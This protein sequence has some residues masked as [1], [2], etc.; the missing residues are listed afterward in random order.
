MFKASSSTCRNTLDFLDDSDTIGH[1]AKISGFLKRKP[2]KITPA[3]FVKAVILAGAKDSISFNAIAWHAGQIGGATSSRQNLH[4]RCDENAVAFLQEVTAHALRQRCQMPPETGAFKRIIIHDGSIQHLADAVAKD[5]PAVSSTEHNKAML[6]LQLSYD[7]LSGEVLYAR[8]EPYPRTDARAAGDLIEHLQPG[9]L[10]LRDLGYYKAAWFQQMNALGAFYIS[11]LKSEVTVFTDSGSN[12]RL[13]KFL[14]RRKEAVV[15]QQ[16]RLG[17][18]GDFHTRLVALRVPPE[19]AAQRRR[20]LHAA[21]KRRHETVSALKLALADLTLL[22]T[23]LSKEQAGGE[24]LRQL[25]RLRWQVEIVFKTLKSNGCMRRLTSHVSNRHHLLALLLGQ[26]LQVILNLRLCRVLSEFDPA[27][28][29]SLL[30]ISGLT[31]ETLAAL[32]LS[33]RSE[34]QWTRHIERLNY[35]CRHDLRTL[36]NLEKLRAELLR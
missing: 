28:P 24:M 20:K 29:P 27:H 30:K 1:L 8:L 5:F 6:R 12:L 13:D 36:K 19:V 33:E 16:V 9:D 4:R 22:I 35:H 26:L 25:Y 32:W 11:R 14:N 17:G 15:D 31:S 7:Y 3:G 10:C 18:T 2:R 23:N 21:A 34:S